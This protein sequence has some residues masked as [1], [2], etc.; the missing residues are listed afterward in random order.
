[1]PRRPEWGLDPMWLTCPESP[2]WYMAT[3]GESTHEPSLLQVNLSSMKLRD[4]MPF[5]LVPLTAS[6]LPSS[7]SMHPAA[8]HPSETATSITTDL[9]ELLSWAATDTSDSVPGHT[10][11]QRSLSVTLGSQPL[12]EEEGSQQSGSTD[13]ATPA[14]AVTLTP[15]NDPCAST[16]TPALPVS[17]A[18]KTIQMASVYPIC[19]PRISLWPKPAELS[20]ELLQ[21]QEKL[22]AALECHL[23]MRATVDLHQWEL[24]LQVELSRHLNNA[25]FNEAMREGMACHSTTATALEE[26]YKNNIMALE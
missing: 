25:Q 7:S 8:E 2:V 18:P 4:E 1:M 19:Q 12:T 17:P 10:A 16:I 26:A 24:D 3:P 13:S 20:E 23:T 15:G 21:L 5:T 9:E 14:P 6:M 22:T 11:P